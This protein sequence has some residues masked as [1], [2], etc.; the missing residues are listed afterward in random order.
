[1]PSD[2]LTRFPLMGVNVAA[3]TFD[4]ALERL[5]NAPRSGGRGRAHFSTAHMLSEAARDPR[6]AGFLNAD[7]SLVLPDGMPLVWVGRRRGYDVARVCGPDMMPA[8]LDRGRDFG[9]THF[10]YGGAP[11]TPERLAETMTARFPGLKVVGTYAPPFRAVGERE[12]P[13]VIDRINQSGAEYVWVGLSTP[14]QDYWAAN[15]RV[16]LTAPMVLAVGAAFDFHTGDLRRAPRWMQRTGTEWLY[17]VGKE[18]GRLW[19]RYA[20][21][22]AH[23]ALATAREELARGR[24]GRGGRG[25]RGVRRRPPRRA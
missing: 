17:R 2:D 4:S 25:E 22:N 20:Y 14:K 18:P 24:S 3:V 15:H 1:M 13:A 23:F 6:L 10:F 16:E 11:G 9:A 5:L 19:R 7:E 12:D 8:L 21:T